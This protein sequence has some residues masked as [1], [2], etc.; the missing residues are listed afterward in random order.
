MT[1]N[2]KAFDS[3]DSYDIVSVNNKPYMFTNLRIKRETVPE[4][5]YAYDVR[6][7]DF[8]SGE[9]AEIK[10]Y[11]MVNHWGTI[12]GTDKIPLDPQFNCYYPAEEEVGFMGDYVKSAEEFKTRYSELLQMCE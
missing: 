5:F 12:I 8:C 1:S 2:K 11:V 9:F 3:I 6:D 10:P 7:D 4:G